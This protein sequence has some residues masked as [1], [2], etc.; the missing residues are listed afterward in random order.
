MQ[1]RWS[2]CT[3][4]AETAAQFNA[5]VTS[6]SVSLSIAFDN[7]LVVVIVVT[8][9]WHSVYISF[10]LALAYHIYF[11]CLIISPD[12]YISSSILVQ[13]YWKCTLCSLLYTSCP[14]RPHFYL[15]ERQHSPHLWQILIPP[16]NVH[17]AIY[18]TGNHFVSRI[19]SP[20]GEGW[21]HDGMDWNKT[22]M[23]TW[24]TF[25]WFQWM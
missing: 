9:V 17:G 18:Y 5:V 2:S 6:N 3:P 25:N 16:R 11:S 21:S 23:H 15:S 12:R 19:I 8:C 24:R 14:K 22:S 10:S 20:T 4:C 7:I 1:H 13:I